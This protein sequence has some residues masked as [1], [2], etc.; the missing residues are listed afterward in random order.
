MDT[1]SKTDGLQGKLVV[2]LKTSEEAVCQPDNAPCQFNYVANIPEVTDMVTE[3]DET[4]LYWTVVV[5]GTGFTGTPAT[6]ELNVAGRPQTTVSVTSTK[7]IFRVSDIN[8][9]TLSN[10]N[11]YFDVGLPKGFDTV[12]R[13]KSFEL[14]PRLISVTPNVGSIGG[15]VLVARVEG[16]GPLSD[17]S[18]AY[19]AL[20]G[21]TLVDNATGTDIC[22]KVKVRSYGELECITTPGVINASTVIGAKSYEENSHSPCNN[23]NS[24][25]CTYEQLTTGTFPVVTSLS[26]SVPGQIVFTGTNFFTTGYNANASYGGF[27]AD[28]IVIDSATQATATWDLGF[29][30]L[31]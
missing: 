18:D 24:A 21:G 2:F 10:M 15:S 5:T 19:W 7:A 3:W 12:V 29:P 1:T 6:T 14:S 8:G 22:S 30:P 28:T 4:N 16:L 9:W 11:V 13:G 17:T 20:H 27:F 25:L 31:A 26:D 23:T